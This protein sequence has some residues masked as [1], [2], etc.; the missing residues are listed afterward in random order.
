MTST[1]MT[2]ATEDQNLIMKAVVGG[3]AVDILKAMKHERQKSQNHNASESSVT[4]LGISL[5]IN[6]FLDSY[7]QR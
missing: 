4:L 6:N 3:S 2:S 1:N 7:L 5:Y